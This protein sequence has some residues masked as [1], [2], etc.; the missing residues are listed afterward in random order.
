VSN[1]F[2]IKGPGGTVVHGIR[3]GTSRWLVTV[4]QGS[5][6]RKMEFGD[7]ML[8]GLLKWLGQDEGYIRRILESR[9]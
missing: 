9:D 6:T 5:A 2:E 7:D 4:R 8:V 1:K 3:I